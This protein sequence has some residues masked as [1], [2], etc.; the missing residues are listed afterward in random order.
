MST[1]EANMQIQVRRQT[2]FIGIAAVMDVFID[3]RRVGSLAHQEM[4]TYTVTKDHVT[5]T[6]GQSFVVSPPLEIQAGQ[7]AVIRFS[8]IG[9]LFSLLGRKAFYLEIQ[10]SS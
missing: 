4:E 3:G 1:R 9:Y 10:K 2:G 8:W 5:L 7:T 6:V